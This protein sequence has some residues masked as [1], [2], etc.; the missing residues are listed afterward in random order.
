MSKIKLFTYSRIPVYADW[1][2]LLLFAGPA[3][4]F[5]NSIAVATKVG[6]FIAI[7]ACVTLHE[8]GHALAGRAVGAYCSEINLSFFGGIAT[9]ATSRS[10]EFFTTLWGPATTACIAIVAQIAHLVWPHPVFEFLMIAN[11]IF[12]LF[13]LLPAWPMDGGRLLRSTLAYIMP[14]E[15]A[16][17]IATIIARVLAV[18]M[19]IVSVMMFMP[20]LA[21]ISVMIFL[22]ARQENLQVN[23]ASISP[24]SG[25]I[26]I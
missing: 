2:L 25:R 10:S 16:T 12:L 1:T 6:M 11:L 18:A 14:Y 3:L 21:F 15:V 22:A 26:E 20:V 5:G 7:F 23:A 13:N 17:Q 24:T 19:F 9:I 4:L 8:F